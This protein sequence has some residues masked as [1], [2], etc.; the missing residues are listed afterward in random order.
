MR[1]GKQRRR[2]SEAEIRRL[3]AGYEGAGQTRAEYCAA[4]GVAI[5]TLDS[6]RRR[7]RSAATKFVEIDLG[8]TG[9]AAAPGTTPQGGVS[10]ALGNGRRLEIA[11]S[12]L[13]RVP[14][15]GEALR[16]LLRWLESA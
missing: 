1:Q 8:Q 16:A 9:L 12:D 7:F 13:A 2:R 15:H 11:W 5:G 10:V 14:S 3:V 6:Y 4:H